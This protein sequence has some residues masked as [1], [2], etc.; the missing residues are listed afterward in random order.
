MFLVGPR[1]IHILVCFALVQLLYETPEILRRHPRRGQGFH[2]L[3]GRG[4][5]GEDVGV[6]AVVFEFLRMLDGLAFVL[7]QAMQ[8]VRA[9]RYSGCSPRMVNGG[10]KSVRQIRSTNLPGLLLAGQG[11]WG[12][13]APKPGSELE[14]KWA[15]RCP[16]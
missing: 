11:N 8:R 2:A 15:R 4:L 10:R 1:R 6:S 9:L 14:M 3:A 5:V 16:A 12:S 7:E 13:G